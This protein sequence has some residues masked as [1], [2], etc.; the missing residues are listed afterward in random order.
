MPL[1]VCVC[2]CKR[3]SVFVKGKEVFK[4]KHLYEHIDD[5]E[6]DEACSLKHV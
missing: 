2:V 1:C 6:F 4:A 5:K 3:V